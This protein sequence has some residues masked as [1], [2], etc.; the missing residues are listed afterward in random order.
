[1]RTLEG[2]RVFFVDDS[3]DD[4]D[5]YTLIFEGQGA[6]VTS[7]GSI[8]EAVGAFEA[9]APNVIVSDLRLPDGD[10]CD[11]VAILR[12]RSGKP[13]VAVA[14]TGDA[15]EEARVRALEAGFDRF[16]VKPIDPSEL[17]DCVVELARRD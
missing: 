3:G 7:C 12:E 11:L 1:M 4:R 16:L 10:G 8:E 9:A 14:L 13:F 2:I 15:R 6:M 17:F 5:L